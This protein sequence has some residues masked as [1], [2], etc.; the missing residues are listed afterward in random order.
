MT[1]TGPTDAAIR[2]RKWTKRTCRAEAL[3]LSLVSLAADTALCNITSLC[4]AKNLPPPRWRPTHRTSLS[5][6]RRRRSVKEVTNGR[7]WLTPSVAGIRPGGGPEHP[8]SAGRT[9]ADGNAMTPGSAHAIG[10]TILL[11]PAADGR[12][13][14]WPVSRRVNKTGT[15]DDDPTLVDEVA[16]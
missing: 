16:A 12:L 1:H 13:R 3:P 6:V 10:G 14:M 7:F 8:I 9:S 11:R 4:Y 5:V 2:P 15:A